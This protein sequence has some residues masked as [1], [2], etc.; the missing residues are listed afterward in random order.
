MSYSDVWGDRSGRYSVRQAHL[1]SLGTNPQAPTKCRSRNYGADSLLPARVPSRARTEVPPPTDLKC[2][3]R[4][5]KR[6][7]VE[8]VHLRPPPLLLFP[9]LLLFRVILPQSPLQTMS[10]MS[11]LG[12]KIPA[13][14]TIG[15]LVIRHGLLRGCILNFGCP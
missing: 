15:V 7:A 2:T 3:S 4:R 12:A 13:L 8:E 1:I 14:K 5:E 9:S 10:F 6:P 11:P